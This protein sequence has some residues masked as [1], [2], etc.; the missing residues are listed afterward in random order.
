MN[1]KKFTSGLKQAAFIS[2]AGLVLALPIYRYAREDPNFYL[3]PGKCSAYATRTAEQEHGLKYDKVPAW[4]LRN[5]QETIDIS[6][7]SLDELPSIAEPGNLI[8]IFYPRSKHNK[9]GRLYTHVAVYEGMDNEGKAIISHNF[10][11]PKTGRLE[12]FLCQYDC[13]LKEIILPIKK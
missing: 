1:R 2:V 5:H 7:K 8:G 11:G 4:E 10:G 12:D 13:E 6:G 3:K 9:E